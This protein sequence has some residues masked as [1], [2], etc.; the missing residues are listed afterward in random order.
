VNGRAATTLC[1]FLI[2]QLS[3][4]GVLIEA[5]DAHLQASLVAS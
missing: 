5:G 2:G 1:E 3:P 4:P